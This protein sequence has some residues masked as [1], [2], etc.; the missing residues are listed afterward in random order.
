MSRGAGA[1]DFV[2]IMIEVKRADI[3][4]GTTHISIVERHAAF[5]ITASDG[6]DDC[7]ILIRSNIL[8][9]ESKILAE[10]VD[11]KLGRAHYAHRKLLVIKASGESNQEPILR[12]FQNGCVILVPSPQI[13][14]E[15][16][17]SLVVFALSMVS[18]GLVYP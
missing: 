9:T 11:I 14:H 16:L 3:C 1:V 13:F 2:F 18:R 7:F 12:C 4:E 10:A 17:R 15:V 5:S 8:V 6:R